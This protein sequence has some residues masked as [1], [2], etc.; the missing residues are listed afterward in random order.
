MQNGGLTLP[1]GAGP[2]FHF[3]ASD[4]PAGAGETGAENIPIAARHQ[5]G[6]RTADDMGSAS[7]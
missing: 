3:S 5:N 7:D 4:H 1:G 2:A 6:C